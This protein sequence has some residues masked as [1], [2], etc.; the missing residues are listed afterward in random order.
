M[1]NKKQHRNFK[2]LYM[3]PDNQPFSEVMSNGKRYTVPRFQRDYSWESEQWEELWQDIEQVQ[4]SRTQHFMGYL[5]FQTE[6]SKEFQVIDGQQ[7]LTTLSILILVALNKLRELVN[8][9]IEVEPNQQRIDTY[10]RSYIDV[11]DPVTLTTKPKL[12]LN[13]HNSAHFTSVVKEWEIVVQRNMIKTNRKINNAFEFFQKKFRNYRSGEEIATTLSNIENG[14]LFTTITVQDDL[15]A[16]TVFETLNSR[17][18]HLSTPDLLKNYLLST[19][20]KE[21]AYHDEQFDDFETAWQ[22][23]LEQLGETE[24]TS[25]LRSYHGIKQ[26]LVNKRELYITLKKDVSLPSKVLPYLE[27]LKKHAPV[28]AALQNHN[29]SFWNNYEGKYSNVRQYLEVLKIF[30]IKTPLSLLMAGYFRLSPEDFISFVKTIAMVSIRYNVI[31]DKAPKNQEQH[32]NKLTNKLVVSDM[33]LSDLINELKPVYPYDEEFEL[34]F[35][36]MT[37]PSRQSSKKILFLL[38]KIEQHLGKKEPSLSLTL[39]HVL[40]FSPSDEWQC[41][42]GRSNYENGIDRLGNMALLP[43][44]EN[45]GQENFAQKRETLQ[46]SGYVINKNI[47]KYEE[48]NMDILEEHQKWLAK[49]A[50]AVWKISQLK[51]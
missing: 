28:Y 35:L 18:L 51:G 10:K 33:T 7:R 20:A 29:D 17:G 15:N 5:V 24:F 22:N 42:F 23:I 1:T 27:D 47:A 39:E 26:K 3:E 11:F 38:R 36:K 8:N 13:R 48:W 21:G 49:Q 2:K 32:Y 19:M 43:S 30:K 9:G 34:A 25:F 45:M 50:K 12:F 14:L 16:Y 46:K 40:P 4:E 6:D 41:Y 44:T 31:C 37:M